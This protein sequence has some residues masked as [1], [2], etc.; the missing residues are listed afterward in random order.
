MPLPPLPGAEFA[1]HPTAF[2]YPSSYATRP[3]MDRRRSSSQWS[4]PQDGTEAADFRTP[5]QAAFCAESLSQPSSGTH[6]P[7]SDQA[8]P[9]AGWQ[10]DSTQRSA[11]IPS[12]DTLH[13]D[14]QPYPGVPFQRRE[15]NS[16]LHR[17]LL[18]ESH[19][20]YPPPGARHTPHSSQSS[21]HSTD[22]ASSAGHADSSRTRNGGRV[23][24][25]LNGRQEVFGWARSTGHLVR[26]TGPVR[27]SERVV[28]F[29]PGS[30]NKLLKDDLE[31][32]PSD[33]KAA[34]DVWIRIQECPAPCVFKV[35]SD[36]PSRPD[37][38][39]PG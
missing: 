14:L 22:S 25:P 27:E 9:A 13:L 5:L 4:H 17:D 31:V 12:L 26:L 11:S 34:F 32:L 38:I 10:V 20:P 36:C 33:S 2:R 7:T 15:S 23:P 6:T 29:L 19:R 30:Y 3:R 39:A 1:Q 21:I 16:S 8:S 28:A 35:S 18:R 37:A 24:R